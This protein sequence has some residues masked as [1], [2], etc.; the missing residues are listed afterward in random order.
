MKKKF[1]PVFFVVMLTSISVHAQQTEKFNPV[2]DKEEINGYTIRLMPLPGR[3][4]GFF[5]MKENKPVYSQLSDPF[6]HKPIGFKNKEDAYKLAEWVAD[7]DSKNGRPPVVISPAVA[8]QLNL[9]GTASNNN[10]SSLK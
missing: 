2:K 5:I 4:F 1:T 9:A 6:S 8:K 10:P 7:E 3:T